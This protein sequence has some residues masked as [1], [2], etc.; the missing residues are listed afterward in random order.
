MACIVK[1]KATKASR[2]GTSS[3]YRYEKAIDIPYE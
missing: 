1:S 3:Y 2:I